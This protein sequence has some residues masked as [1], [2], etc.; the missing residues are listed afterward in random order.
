MSGNFDNFGFFHQ[1][2]LVPARMT[3]RL[4]RNK[5]NAYFVILNPVLNLFQ[6]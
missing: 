4:C 1:P 6:Y 2:E 5:G 3:F